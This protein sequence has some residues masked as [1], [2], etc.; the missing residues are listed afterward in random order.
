MKSFNF[1][2][3]RVN[4]VD[5][6]YC[7]ASWRYLREY[8]I[9]HRDIALL[10]SLDD[11][12]KIKCG[13]PSYPVAAVERGKKVIV[14]AGQVMA[15]GDHNFTKFGIIPSVS[16]VVCICYSVGL[17]VLKFIMIALNVCTIFQSIFH[18]NV[19]NVLFYSFHPCILSSP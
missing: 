14:G 4:H 10:V 8:A 2:Q 7:A 6:H 11:K 12:H 15:V 17:V 9:K 16:L 18:Y 3:V 13:E 1:L 5:A 19:S